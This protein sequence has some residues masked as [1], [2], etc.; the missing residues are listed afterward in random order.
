M[1]FSSKSFSNPHKTKRCWCHVITYVHYQL[2]TATKFTLIHRWVIY[3]HSIRMQHLPPWE[4]EHT[5]RIINCVFS[6]RML[7]SCQW[8]FMWNKHHTRLRELLFSNLDLETGYSDCS[9]QVFREMP[10][11]Y[12]RPCEMVTLRGEL[13]IM[14]YYCYLMY[15][16]L[17]N[18]ITNIIF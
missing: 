18:F 5:V 17:W 2:C 14:M 15:P 11:D 4:T 6:K 1:K 13:T 12:G 8:G 7:I 3:V 9:L 10:W 16:I